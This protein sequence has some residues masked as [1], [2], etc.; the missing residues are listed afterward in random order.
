MWAALK[1]ARAASSG[2]MQAQGRWRYN[3]RD[4][5]AFVIEEA[6]TSAAQAIQQQ[7]L[8]YADCLCREVIDRA[9]AA[10]DKTATARAFNLLAT[11]AAL[12]NMPQF[13]LR[14]LR[15][16]V[17]LAPDFAIAAQNLAALESGLKAGS[18][19][20]PAPHPGPRYLLIKAWGWGFWSDVDHVLGCLLLA[21]MTGRTPVIHWGGNSLYSDD[22]ARSAWD[23]FF[24]PPSNVP[25][26]DLQKRGHSYF[27]PKWNVDNLLQPELNKMSGDG[28]RLS[29]VNFLN[30]PENVI[31][32]D[33]FVALPNVAPWLDRDVDVQQ[34]YRQIIPKFLKVQPHI[35]AEIDAFYARHLA[36]SPFL[37]VHMRGSDKVL[38]QRGIHDI[39]ARYFEHVDRVLGDS[40]LRL[41]LLTDM[42]Q[43]V[44][45]FR[46][47]YGER[48]ITTDAERTP[49]EKAF[50]TQPG[51]KIRRGVEVIRDTY[52]AARADKLIGNGASNVTAMVYNLKQWDDRDVTLLSPNWMLRRNA[53]LYKS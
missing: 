11:V 33:F 14:Y 30:R 28:A 1:R 23:N 31:V 9:R 32:S 7:Q 44:A 2:K 10:V 13:A 27:P 26:G 35:L 51:N 52:L 19:A 17:A 15:E 6:L 25:I 38:D 22:P 42:E 41:F 53:G 43:A 18:F 37:A 40:R 16:A 8:Q 5:M 4:R 34:L 24:Q 12:A 21:E 20:T 29:V 48:V 36:D 45:E 50:Y 49:D 39:N 46:R 47:R 3:L